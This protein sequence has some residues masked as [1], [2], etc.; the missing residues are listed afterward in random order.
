MAKI[1]LSLFRPNYKGLWNDSTLYKKNDVVSY[2]GSSYICLQD[3]PAEY[4]IA[5]STAVSTTSY[6][7]DNSRM[8]LV[9]KDPFDAT[10]WQ[11][12]ARGASY[13]HQWRPHIRYDR[14]DIVGYGNDV[15][16][17][18]Q[19]G[20]NIWPLDS[21]FWTLI[22][23]SSK[24][25]TLH[26]VIGHNNAPLGWQ[27]NLGDVCDS[28]STSP[29][30]AFYISADGNAYSMGGHSVN[31]G[32]GT[33]ENY[34]S[35]GF[36]KTYNPCF[37]FSGYFSGTLPTPD[38]ETPKCI[39]VISRWALTMY[40]FNNGEVYS[41]GYNGYGQLGQG[42][43]SNYG[44]SQRVSN[45]ATTDCAGNTIPK[46][47]N[48]SKIVKIE[49]NGKGDQESYTHCL[50]LDN[51]GGVWA[52]GYNGAGQLGLGPGTTTDGSGISTTNQSRPVKIAQE[53]FENK[54]IVDI[55]TTGAGSYG[56]SYFVDEDECIW[57]AGASYNG[58]GGTGG[59][60]WRYIPTPIK[61]FN[62]KPFG[63]VKKVLIRDDN[64]NNT[65]FGIHV[66]DGNGELWFGG[67]AWQQDV[68]G[69]LNNAGTSNPA[70]KKYAWSWGNDHRIDNVWT[71][72]T[73]ADYTLY[74]REKGTGL[75]WAW[76]SNIYGQLGDT[77][78]HQYNAQSGG[79]MGQPTLVKRVKNLVQVANFTNGNY[80]S[81]N[82]PTI[83]LLDEQGRAWGIG[84]NGYG[85][86]SL[87]WTGFSNG[88]D[89]YYQNSQIIPT[90]PNQ[91]QPVKTFSGVKIR[92]IKGWNY[93]FWASFVH[94]NGMFILDSGQAAMS[95]SDANHA[96]GTNGG[97]YCFQ[98]HINSYMYRIIFGAVNG[99][100]YR[101]LMHT[102]PAG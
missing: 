76:G 32:V 89:A 6:H 74:M 57:F 50:A 78:N 13:Q 26:A 14:G 42:N 15:Y 22:L 84:H 37:M 96:D 100:A 72:G 82:Y 65:Y 102:Y 17:C 67:G 52:W 21:N 99:W 73:N 75:T 77:P 46:T 1:D 39:Q 81:T 2:R 93:L 59:N 44:R 68:H 58:E 62:F 25:S 61:L 38:G 10:F 88:Y 28:E 92:D 18:V 56:R 8:A 53:Y 4:T 41:A 86:L 29:E 79:I 83:C 3:I 64:G 54:R 98:G 101:A 19:A 80:S 30:I 33:G 12:F 55:F 97:Y 7:F 34:G 70:F 20:K 69:N 48:Q 90:G 87:G 49:V 60:V 45:T 51:A 94:D 9:T 71:I 95:G 24:Q 23:K 16:V 27:R 40:L 85:S 11:Q 31:Y 47:F 35:Q 36:T 91:F 66:L 43:T 5:G 63:G